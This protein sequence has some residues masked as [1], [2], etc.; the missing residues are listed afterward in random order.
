[1]F[2][3]RSI[4]VW[5][6]MCTRHI[7]AIHIHFMFKNK[8]MTC[9]KEWKETDEKILC[10]WPKWSNTTISNSAT[11]RDFSKK[12]F[13]LKRIIAMPVDRLQMI[14]SHSKIDFISNSILRLPRNCKRKKW[15]ANLERLSITQI[16]IISTFVT[17]QFIVVQ[18]F[19][20]VRSCLIGQ[21]DRNN[22]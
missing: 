15:M 6:R 3:I 18:T 21:N 2:V 12:S 10:T 17:N 20:R 13:N 9:D 5:S 11:N 4:C 7:H 19:V 8:W 1:M 16:T 22:K 14:G